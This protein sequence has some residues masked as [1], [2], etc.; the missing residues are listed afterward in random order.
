[1]HFIAFSPAALLRFVT[2]AQRHRLTEA[3][4]CAA[5]RA[6]H[7]AHPHGIVPVASVEQAVTDATIAATLAALDARAARN[8]ATVAVAAD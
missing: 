2:L 7:A 1:M 5:V 3:E 6:L 8:G 4:T